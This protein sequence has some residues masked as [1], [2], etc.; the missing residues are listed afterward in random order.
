[1]TTL[2]HLNE[3][4]Y[5]S[6]YNIR[7]TYVYGLYLEL[8]HLYILEDICSMS[9]PLSLK[10]IKEGGIFNLLKNLFILKN[11]CLY[12]KAMINEKDGLLKA[13]EIPVIAKNKKGPM[14][15]RSSRTLNWCKGL[16]L[17]SSMDGC[18]NCQRW[19]YKQ[20]HIWWRQTYK[21]RKRYRL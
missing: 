11:H 18:R 2:V 14:N 5:C 21:E 16:C 15:E 6:W 19:F 17:P 9:I 3:P 13:A 7:I 8:C 4:L 10:E 20:D 12:T 1:M